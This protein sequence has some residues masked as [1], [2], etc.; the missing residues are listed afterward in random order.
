MTTATTCRITMREM[1]DSNL[2]T[3]LLLRDQVTDAANGMNLHL[4]TALGKLLAQ[5]MDVNLDRIRCHVA[6]M[7]EDV[8]FDLLLGDDAALAAHQELQHLGL[9]G[10]EELG[11]VVDRGLPIPGGE[12]EIGDAQIAA[13]QLA[14]PTQLGFQP[15]DQFLQREGLYQVVVG[16]AAQSMDA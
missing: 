14:W 8:V 11:L 16:P 6:G 3:L 10:R 2:G 4:C 7:S 13:E 5:P 12:F 9:A 1:I 15:R